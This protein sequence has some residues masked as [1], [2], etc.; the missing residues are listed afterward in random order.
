MKR[1]EINGA[2]KRALAILRENNFILPSFA[3]WE[4]GDWINHASE[5]DNIKK[6]GLGW[7]VTDFGAG[8]F[9]HV[10]SVLF[11]VRNGCLGDPKPGTPYAEKIIFQLHEAE[12][13]IPFHFHKIKTEDIINRGGGVLMLELY[14]SAPEGGLDRESDIR[15]KMDGF[16]QTLPAGSIVEIE[17]GCSITLHPGLH[18]RF[19]AKK[20]AGD[21]I[22][23]EVSSIN[24]DDTDNVFLE[25]G[26]RFSEIEEDEPAF[27][28]LCNEYGL[29]QEKAVK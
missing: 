4:M 16:I 7:D 1:S 28:P 6:I 23:G 5:L 29:L 18:H 27:V 9:A 21:L 8:D 3:Y 13:E 15:V 12:Q 17:K 25:V 19:W 22:V 10:G 14:K 2:I 26:R 20:G 11:T 24:D